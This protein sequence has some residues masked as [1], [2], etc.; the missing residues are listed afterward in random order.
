MV[1]IN[2]LNLEP[3]ATSSQAPQASTPAP[4]VPGKVT[5]GTPP[6][7]E[8]QRGKEGFKGEDSDSQSTSGKE[9]THHYYE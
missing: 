2:A 1:R 5:S 7:Q 6:S 8:E 3:T 4:S 9:F